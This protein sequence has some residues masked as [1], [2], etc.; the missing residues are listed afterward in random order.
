MGGARITVSGAPEAS[1]W[2]MMLA[3]FVGLGLLGYRGNS[4]S[5]HSLAPRTTA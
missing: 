1:T 3:G 4:L 5:K 2:V